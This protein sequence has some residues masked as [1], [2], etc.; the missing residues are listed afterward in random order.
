MGSGV[1]S[2]G[3]LNQHDQNTLFSAFL[4]LLNAGDEVNLFE[5]YY[6]YHAINLVSTLA[7]PL[8]VRMTPP[9]WTFSRDDLDNVVT[10]KT[11]AILINTPG[12]PS[13]KVFTTEEQKPFPNSQLR[14]ISSYLPTKSMNTLFMTA[15]NTSRRQVYPVCAN[16]RSW[17]RVYPK[18]TALPAGGLDTLSAMP[19]GQRLSDTLA[20]CFTPVHLHLCRWVLRWGSCIWTQ[21]FMIIFQESTRKNVI[22]FAMR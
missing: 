16:V 11:K 2:V 15:S 19:S 7:V 22:A 17:Y 6:G 18:L 10:E 13:G 5:P 8:Y 3:G 12:N 21:N 4:A 1:R 14:T 9:D 20:I